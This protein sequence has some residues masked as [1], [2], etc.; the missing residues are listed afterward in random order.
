MKKVLVVLVAAAVVSSAIFAVSCESVSVEV[1][2]KWNGFL[3][4]KSVNENHLKD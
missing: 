3:F 1:K 4:H 2:L